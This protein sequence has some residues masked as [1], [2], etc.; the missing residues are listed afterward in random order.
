MD[1][2]LTLIK[3]CEEMPNW[4]DIKVNLILQKIGAKDID[5]GLEILRRTN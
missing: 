4:L 3:P 1:N 5:E 2:N